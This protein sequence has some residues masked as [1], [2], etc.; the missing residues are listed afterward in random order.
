M[1][2]SASVRLRRRS[3]VVNNGG[4]TM[5]G[6]MMDELARFQAEMAALE[7]DADEPKSETVA[8]A[9]EPTHTPTTTNDAAPTTTVGPAPRPGPPPAPVSTHGPSARPMPGR[10]VAGPTSRATIARE[11]ER[12]PAGPSARP[13]VAPTTMVM[14]YDAQGHPVGM[15][16]AATH[17]GGSLKKNFKPIG[18]ALAR[19]AGGDKWD[20]A[21]LAEWPEND[22]R[23]FVGN[24]GNECSDDMLGRAFAKYPSFAKAKVVKDKMNPG[25]NKGYG[26]VSFLELADFASA[27]KEME[28]KFIGNRPVKLRKSTWNE[29][30]DDKRKVKGLGAKK[31]QPMHKRKHIA[32]EP[33]VLGV[34]KKS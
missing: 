30:T 26:F 7:A 29:R 9:K 27:M 8:A 32:V 3:L 19:S 11:A 13:N 18:K 6:D 28:G 12:V 5:S 21:T 16:A 22:H 24:L 4:E 31:F 2:E 1:N 33:S 14:T 34:H 10:V 15:V 20:D 23:I 17:A 25:K